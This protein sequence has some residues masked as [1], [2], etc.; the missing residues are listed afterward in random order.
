MQG[1]LDSCNWLNSS[2]LLP[3]SVTSEGGRE[4]EKGRVRLEEVSKNG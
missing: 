3:T 2:L 1:P 4:G